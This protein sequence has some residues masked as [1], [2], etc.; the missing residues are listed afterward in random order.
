MYKIKD[1]NLQID[2]QNNLETFTSKGKNKP[3][4]DKNNKKN[5]LPICKNLNQVKKPDNCGCP[6]DKKWKLISGKKYGCV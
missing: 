2:L 5:C 4:C 6:I 3:I 1:I